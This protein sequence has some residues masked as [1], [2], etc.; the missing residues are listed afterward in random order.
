M[1]IS[2]IKTPGVYINEIDAFP[3]SIAQVATA[4]PAFVG[5]TE[6]ATSLNVPTRISSLMEYEQIFGGAPVPA[7]I[8]VDLDSNLLP[9]D[10][11]SV[12]ESN[13]KLYNSMRLFYANGGGECYIVSIGLY[14]GGSDSTAIT[15][16]KF[17]DGIDKLEK[18]DEP[19]LLLFPDA[20]NLSAA[21]LGA[22]QTHALA[23]CQ[24]LM[25]RFTIMDVKQDAN[26]ID[27]SED[28]RDEIGNQNLK[29]GAAYY[30]YLQANFPFQFR[31]NDINGIAGGKVNFAGIYAT[32]LFVSSLL[33]KFDITYKKVYQSTPPEGF[34]TQWDNL[35]KSNYSIDILDDTQDYVDQLWS[36]LKILG[37]TS[38]LAS[39][40]KGYVETLI[41]ISLKQ[42]AQK[43][44]DFSSA[45][46]DLQTP[47]ADPEVDPLVD[48]DDLDPNPEADFDDIIWKSVSF[49]ASGTNPYSGTALSTSGFADQGKIQAALDKLNSQI[50][51]AMNSAMSALENY[52]MEEENNL[53]SNIPLFSIIVSKLSQS[54]NTVPP[55]GAIAGIYAQ[56]DATRGVWKAPANISV[57][58]IIGLADDINDKDQENMN[59]HETGK[60]I[61]AIRKFTGRGNL[62]WGARTLA[63]NSNDWRYINVRRLA[64][65][66]EESV[67]KAC[68]QFVFEPNVAQTWVNV[69]GMIENYLT[70]L[71]NDGA[72]AGAKPEHAFFVAVGLNQTMSA[73]DI[74]EGRM[75]VKIGY[76]PSRPA[77]F[78]ILEFKQMQQKS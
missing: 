47:G 21:D 65:M 52:V 51:A 68:M 69:K 71:W 43:I 36:Y 1:N 40:F 10:T 35:D 17:T 18:Y 60:S 64:N 12:T 20:V 61:N 67:K 59:I 15:K 75:I 8:T 2:A 16:L 66:I 72:L 44:V 13:F 74:L 45:Y 58:G 6:K 37:Q 73:Q 63:G 76:A 77:E 42:Y 5:Y 50:I 32:D 11:S 46:N 33:S 19:T 55:S 78:I 24:K 29:Y 57:N 56:T 27:D 62:V 38:T 70:T 31:F 30:P 49:T 22:V 3:P 9:L 41:S 54:M 28:F 7:N 48:L 23:Q 4:I 53:I 25:D 39:P 34:S 14:S 26:L